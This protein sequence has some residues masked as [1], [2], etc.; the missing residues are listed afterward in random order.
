MSL[1][2]DVRAGI[3]ANLDSIEDVQ[4]SAYVLSNPT[5]PVIWVRPRPES[6]TYHRAM[7]DGLSELVMLV[8]A[9]VGTPTD[10]GAQKH[11]DR[12]LDLTGPDSVKAA[13]ESDKT[14]GGVADDLV[15]QECTGYLEYQRPDGS[16]ALGA[17]W[18][19]L[20]YAS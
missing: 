12:F 8:Q 16:T 4:I 10:V 15:V 2:G 18:Q 5:P 19:V 1:L 17:E 3:A 13:V 7:G 6:S 9:Y 11:L 14:L 20:V